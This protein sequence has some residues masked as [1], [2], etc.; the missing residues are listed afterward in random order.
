MTAVLVHGVPETERVW[1]ALRGEL[2]HSDV[3][4]LSLPGFGC[5]MP[6]GFMPTKEGYLD[7][8][9]AE[10]ERFG[11][12]V[13]LVGHDWGGI[14]TVR[15]VSVRPDLVRTWMTDSAGV[16][17][18]DYVW[19]DIAKIW[20]TPGE[21]ESFMDGWLAL[22][23]DLKV[24]TF[25]GVAAT[26]PV[27]AMADAIDGRMTDAVLMLYRSALAV[28][29][30][31]GPAFADIPKPG[32]VLVAND[33]PFLEPTRARRSAERAGARL[34]ELDGQGHWWMLGD[35]TGAARLLDDF[36]ASGT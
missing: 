5:P 4:A 31:W 35:P 17:D 2:E 23:Q 3:V 26:D 21:G 7:W 16:A 18:P 6:D 24:A 27:L 20:Q 25:S 11:E 15:L 32:A 13:D 36:W 1:D 34:L 33:D 28:H 10:L 29:E 22:P 9:I 12:P 8:L 19:H 14:L 30:E